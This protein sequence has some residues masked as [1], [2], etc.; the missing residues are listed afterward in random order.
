MFSTSSVFPDRNYTEESSSEDS[1]DDES[2]E[3]EEEGEEE[4]EEEDYEVAGL[5]CKY[6]VCFYVNPMV[7]Y[8]DLER[9]SWQ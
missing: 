3:E 1:E 4:E 8:G 5:R 2:E 9:P 6:S 7:F